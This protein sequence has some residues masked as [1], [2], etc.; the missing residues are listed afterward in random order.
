MTVQATGTSGATTK[1]RPPV[2]RHLASRG[3]GEGLAGALGA[4]CAG[5]VEG[6]R[7]RT[8]LTGADTDSS[9]ERAAACRDWSRSVSAMLPRHSLRARER[10]AVVLP[11]PWWCGDGSCIG[12]RGD[13]ARLGC[14]QRGPTRG[15]GV[16][17]RTAAIVLVHDERGG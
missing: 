10:A 4:R 15:V 2:R 12:E 7:A 1:P 16:K 8:R 9:D 11:R 13:A 3:D 17:R 5:R 6:I 14:W